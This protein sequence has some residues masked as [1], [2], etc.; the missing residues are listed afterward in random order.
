MTPKTEKKLHKTLDNPLFQA[1][2]QVENL[3][4]FGG[5]S[6]SKKR[7]SAELV[8]YEKNII[9]KRWTKEHHS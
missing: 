1:I 2:E 6:W 3:L 7:I 5:K 4:S 9:S 8:Q